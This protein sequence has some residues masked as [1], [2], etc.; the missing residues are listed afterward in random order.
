MNSCH[1]KTIV[2]SALIALVALAATGQAMA[3]A[4]PEAEKCF[5]IVKAGKNDCQTATNA[6]AGHVKTDGRGD[7]W[8]FVPKGS[9]ERIVGGSLTARK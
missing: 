1:H 6:C 9:C 4:K 8:V 3:D 2:G 7:A 5:G